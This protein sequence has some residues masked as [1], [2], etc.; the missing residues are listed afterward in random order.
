MESYIYPPT[1]TQTISKWPRFFSVSCDRHYGKRG[2]TSRAEQRL[3]LWQVPLCV[4]RSFAAW[5]LLLHPS[6][7]P[8]AL[9]LL[10]G[11]LTFMCVMRVMYMW[12]VRVMC[13]GWMCHVWWMHL[14]YIIMMNACNV[15]MMMSA[16]MGCKCYAFPKVE[17]LVFGVEIC[18]VVKVGLLQVWHHDCHFVFIVFLVCT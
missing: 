16:W 14:M 13:V 11:A 15:Y 4:A 10:Q 5:S 2:E 6:L 17:R 12:S 1:L 7:H 18:W 9:L 8:C 3:C